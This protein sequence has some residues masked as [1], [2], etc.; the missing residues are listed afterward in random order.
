[1]PSQ[2]TGLENQEIGL[3]NV[4]EMTYFV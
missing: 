4:F 3:E 1:M 2:E